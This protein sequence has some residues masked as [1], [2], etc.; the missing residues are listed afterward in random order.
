[1][2]FYLNID[3]VGVFFINHQLHVQPLVSVNLDVRGVCDLNIQLK[4]SLRRLK[5]AEDENGE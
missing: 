1:M 3:L 4:L 2:V 5:T